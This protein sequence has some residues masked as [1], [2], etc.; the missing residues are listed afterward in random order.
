MK[1]TTTQQKTR[2]SKFARIVLAGIIATIAFNGVMYVDIAITGI[3][4]DI[5]ATMGSLTVGESEY[6]ETV[7][8]VIHFANGIGLALLFGYVALPIS[9]KIIKL[10]V[11]VYAIVFAIVEL[12]IAVW[13]VMLPM[14][15]AG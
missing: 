5:V 2:G 1:K 3:P 9:K 8:H 15:G 14:L 10:P 12:V 13:F 7:G 4:L 11:I 6:T